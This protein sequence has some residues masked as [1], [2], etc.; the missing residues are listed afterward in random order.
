MVE[1]KVMEIQGLL[2]QLR[3]KYEDFQKNVISKA[4]FT[5]LEEKIN[6]RIDM[7]ETAL[8]RPGVAGANA[9]DV[10]KAKAFFEYVRKGKA[11][12]PSDLKTALVA[13]DDTSGILIP[14]E[15][16]AE[17]QM[18]LPNITVMRNLCTVMPV[19]SDRL[20]RRSLTNVTVGWGKLEA[21]D[22]ADLGDFESSVTAGEAYVHV[23]NLNGLI[24]LG[25]D[26]LADSDAMLE[27]I[28]RD[29]FANA[30]AEA[31]D[32][33]FI[34]GGGHTAGE[35][36]GIVMAKDASNALLV[37]RVDGVVPGTITVD[38]LIEL[39][40]AVP[41][42]YKRNA[43]F[44]MSSATERVI[45]KLKA[46]CEVTSEVVPGTIYYH[47]GASNIPLWEPSLQAGRP[48][49]L[50]GYP[51][52][53][54]DAM[55][56]PIWNEDEVANKAVI[57]FGNFKLGY[58]IL[59]RAGMSVQRLTELYAEQDLVGLKVKKRVGGGVVRPDAMAVLQLASPNAE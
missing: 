14:A 39:E 11:E 43:A 45:R 49:T 56:A 54:N 12:I 18:A 24:K 36:E 27:G 2:K 19:N 35:P 44:I 57:I 40:Y 21:S 22:T 52:Y 34:M 4:E 47:T 17:I 28:L 29:A 31:E 5:Q 59:D 53:N 58:V 8:N 25:E 55:Q 3:E 41:A 42:K 50:M 33:A 37:P 9:K 16:E 7:L 38:D 48:A 6:G 15:L 23:E 26:L 10:T 32:T 20:R 13:S 30:M 1:D 46:S 51:V